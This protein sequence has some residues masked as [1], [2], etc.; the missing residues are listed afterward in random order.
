MSSWILGLILG[1]TLLGAL[2]PFCLLLGQ[3]SSG[4]E[5]GGSVE[6]GGA[7]GLGRAQGAGERLKHCVLGSQLKRGLELCD[8]VAKKSLTRKER[9]RRRERRGKVPVVYIV[10]VCARVGL[11][12]V[13]GNM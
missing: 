11:W 3:K 13:Q 1:L 5:A 8:A 2:L 6:S 9:S 12:C 4:V 7:E 10:C